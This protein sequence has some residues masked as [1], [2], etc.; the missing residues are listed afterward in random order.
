MRKEKKNKTYKASNKNKNLKSFF[1]DSSS[2][3][4]LTLST[5]KSG[6]S[7]SDI[8]KRALKMY[9]TEENDIKNGTPTVPPRNII[10]NIKIEDDISSVGSSGSDKDDSVMST[11]NTSS[12]NIIIAKNIKKNKQRLIKNP[13]LNGL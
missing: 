4:S 9:R 8:L 7:W 3:S 6:T 13:M 5:V 2:E 12:I 11:K 1:N 10:T